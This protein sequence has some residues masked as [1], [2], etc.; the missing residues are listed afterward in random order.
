MES[1]K[2]LYR[3]RRREKNCEKGS[4]RSV[5]IEKMKRETAGKPGRAL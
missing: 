5:A 1:L 3:E 2:N 4:S